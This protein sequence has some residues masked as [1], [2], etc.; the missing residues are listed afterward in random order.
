MTSHP[1]LYIFLP[2]CSLPICLLRILRLFPLMYYWTDGISPL[3]LSNL[4]FYSCFILYLSDL[5]FSS[6]LTILLEKHPVEHIFNVGN[7]ETVTVKEW[8]E[9]CYQI[10]GKTVHFV[11]VEKSVPQRNYFCFYDYEYVL[12]V[13]K[14]NELMSDTIPLMQGLCEEFEW[15]R[16]NLDSIYNRKPY[17]EYIDNNLVKK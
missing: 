16:N 1:F 15:Y 11:S 3:L 5:F 10:A 9:M 12:D 2:N 7:R 17:M 4:Y 8:V 13:S 14:E 6:W